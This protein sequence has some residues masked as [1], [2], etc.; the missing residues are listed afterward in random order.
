MRLG[1]F[2][3]ASC[4]TPFTDKKSSGI[5]MG[6]ICEKHSRRVEDGLKCEQKNNDRVAPF[7]TGYG[8]PKP[9][10][11]GKGNFKIVDSWWRPSNGAGLAKLY[12]FAISG[13]VGKIFFLSEIFSFFGQ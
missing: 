8:C 1:Q 10:C 11:L 12:G 7:K 2:N 9:T 6:Y 3:D 5:G 4:R 13:T